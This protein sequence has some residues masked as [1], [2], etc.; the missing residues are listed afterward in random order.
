MRECCLQRNAAR[1]N[2]QVVPLGK[3]TVGDAGKPDTF[4]GHLYEDLQRLESTPRLARDQKRR[5]RWHGHLGYASVTGLQPFGTDV[6]NQ[7]LGDSAGIA[8]TFVQ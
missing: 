5:R 8:D 3:L 2:R 7:A 1:C 4:Q 6:F